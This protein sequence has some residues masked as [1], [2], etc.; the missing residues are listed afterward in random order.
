M[1]LFVLGIV[2]GA[3]ISVGTIWVFRKYIWKKPEREIVI[4]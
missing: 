4:A 1:L 2:L 3:A